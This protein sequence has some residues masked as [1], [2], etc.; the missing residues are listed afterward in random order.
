MCMGILSS[1]ISVN[2]VYSSHRGLERA[3][4]PLE[5]GLQMVLSHHVALGACILW[6]S[7]HALNRCPVPDLS[8]FTPTP[9]PSLR[10]RSHFKQSSVLPNPSWGWGAIQR[11]PDACIMSQNP[12]CVNSGL[13]LHILSSCLGPSDSLKQKRFQVTTGAEKSLTGSYHGHTQGKLCLGHDHQR[14]IFARPWYPEHSLTLSNRDL[15][16]S[17]TQSG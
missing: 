9:A 10:V 5:L 11:E 8:L 16:V 13:H 17:L 3:A 14:E 6:E 7:S 4:G 2:H 15:A 1:W 12:Y